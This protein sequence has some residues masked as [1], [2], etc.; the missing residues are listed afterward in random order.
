MSMTAGPDFVED[1]DSSQGY[2]DRWASGCFCFSDL[3]CRFCDTYLSKQSHCG[4]SAINR[5]QG[6]LLK[7][8]TQNTFFTPDVRKSSFRIKRHVSVAGLRSL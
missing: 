8:Q 4:A 5:S 6:P 3:S 1:E 2:R 7:I